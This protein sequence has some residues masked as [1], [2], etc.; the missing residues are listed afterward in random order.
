MYKFLNVHPEN[1]RV[2]DCVKRAITTVTGIDYQQVQLELNRYKKIS[3][4]AKF[5]DN[6]NWKGY[7]E[8]VLHLKKLSF[9][10]EPGVPRMNGERFCE[11]YPKG[12]YL[13]RMAHHLTACIDGVIYDTW[14]CSDKCVY[15]AYEFK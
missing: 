8:N 4:C 11:L 6:K 15:N 12:K 3:G 13:L 10:A 7:V 5:N 9:P 14:D 1:K 2:A